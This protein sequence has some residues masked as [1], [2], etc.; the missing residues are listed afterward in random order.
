MK[1]RPGA[2]RIQ[3]KV[4]PGAKQNQVTEHTDQ[5]WEVRVRAPAQDG[6]ANEAVA[7]VLA[8]H[9]GLAKSAVTIE[10]GHTSRLK[11]VSISD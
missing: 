3:V 1:P 2:K 5:P 7:A 4:K 10:K 9:L 8:E 11:T 6:K